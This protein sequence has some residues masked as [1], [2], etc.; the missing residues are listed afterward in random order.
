[1]PFAAFRD[2]AR[3]ASLSATAELLVNSARSYASPSYWKY[4]NTTLWCILNGLHAAGYNSAESEPISMKFGKLSAKIN[5]YD[6]REI[7]HDDA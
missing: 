4:S 5:L 2:A 1:M 6:L 7:W 3:R